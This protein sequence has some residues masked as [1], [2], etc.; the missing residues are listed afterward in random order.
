MDEAIRKKILTLLD[1]HRI[2]TVATLR[3]DGSPHTVVTWY[4]WADGRVLLNMAASRL[5]LRF[6]RRDPRAALTA[7]PPGDWSSR[8]KPRKTMNKLKKFKKLFSPSTLAAT[9][10]TGM[11]ASSVVVMATCAEVSAVGVLPLR[12]PSGEICAQQTCQQPGSNGRQYY[13][14]CSSSEICGQVTRRSK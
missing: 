10:A 11:L 8:D 4:D 7:F 12:C 1:E 6:M 14:C 2:M 13:F 5:R 9:V 3:P